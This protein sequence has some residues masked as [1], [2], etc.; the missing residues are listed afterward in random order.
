[1][2]VAQQDNFLDP[3]G[4]G[5]PLAQRLVWRESLLCVVS[6]VSSLGSMD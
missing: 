1:M 2:K 4:V 5:N 6:C 3:G